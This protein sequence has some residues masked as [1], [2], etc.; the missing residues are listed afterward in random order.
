[1]KGDRVLDNSGII[2]LGPKCFSQTRML[3]QNILFFIIFIG[4][5]A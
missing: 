3:K 4:M 2:H 1:M 5:E